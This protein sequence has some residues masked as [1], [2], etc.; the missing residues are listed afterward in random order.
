MRT[1]RV[2]GDRRVGGG[3]GG[4]VVREQVMCTQHYATV[5]AWMCLLLRF[6]EGC[7]KRVVW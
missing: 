2:S 5:L 7:Y 1:Y 4:G 3:G 6:A